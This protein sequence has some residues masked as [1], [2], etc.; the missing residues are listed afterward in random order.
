MVCEPL[1]YAISNGV[2]S[3]SV[4][5]HR[6]RRSC[7]DNQPV[8]IAPNFTPRAVGRLTGKMSYPVS[9][10]PRTEESPM[11]A[12]LRLVTRHN[13]NRSVPIRPANAEL[14]SREYLTPQE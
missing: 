8:A 9:Q 12:Q 10:F 2:R 13:L 5:G 4:V 1:R 7:T 11:N 3:N 6:M 14:R